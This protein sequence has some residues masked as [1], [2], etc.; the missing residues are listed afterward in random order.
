VFTNA[1]PGPS[2]MQTAGDCQRRDCDGDG[3]AVEV[4]DNTDLPS[5]TSECT[6]DGCIG[7]APQFVPK[8]DNTECAVTGHCVAGVCLECAV[9]GNCPGA[10]DFCQAR[11][12]IDMKCGLVFEQAGVA[13]PPTEQVAG[14]CKTI[15]CD[16]AGSTQTGANDADLPVDGI[17]CTMDVCTAG[18]ASHSPRLAG[19]A[20]DQD[21]G[22]VCDGS[23][24]C[25]E[26]AAPGDCVTGICTDGLCVAA[27]CIDTIKN[28]SETD[29]DCGGPQCGPCADGLDCS[30]GGDCESA[31]C[32]GM[33]CQVPACNDS[34]HNGTET[35]IDCGGSCPANCA[36]GEG[37]LTGQ[38][39][40]SAVC[41]SNVCQASSCFDTL[42][43]GTETDNDCGGS[44]AKDCL[45]GQGCVSATDCTTGR[46]K[47]GACVLLNFCDATTATDLTGMGAITVDFGGSSGDYTPAC[48]KIS[49]GTAVTFMG[50]FNPHPLD[51]GVCDGGNDTPDPAS[52]FMPETSSGSTKTFMMNTVGAFPYYC[53]LHFNNNG[54]LGA[55]YVVP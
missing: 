25:V 46:C 44:C 32:Q 30:V 2:T 12:C 39:C 48:F 24:A 28:G 53:P 26:C 21:G 52:P 49:L 42:K 40:L 11:T 45:V 20:C 18:V 37:C 54:F 38:D 8:S 16:G 29:V 34:A 35:D 5:D 1:E 15:E 31:V 43:N 22:L 55:A 51:G 17:E 3:N 7:G 23:G 19:T 36:N 10:D 33:T 4:D 41:T 14:D 6:I 27:A 9:P 13:L 47:N 50:N